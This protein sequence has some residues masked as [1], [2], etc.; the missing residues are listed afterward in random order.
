M[1]NQIFK[2]DILLTQIE[3]INENLIFFSDRDSGIILT[4]SMTVLQC[5]TRLCSFFVKSD[6]NR[7]RNDLMDLCVKIESFSWAYLVSFVPKIRHNARNALTQVVK[8]YRLSST[9][10]LVEL[11]DK[12]MKLSWK[13]KTKYVVLSSVA[14][15]GNSD[16]ILSACPDL[17]KSLMKNVQDPTIENLCSDLYEIMMTRF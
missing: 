2:V 17:T 1:N 5:V 12:A 14:K 13:Q 9:E 4:H 16:L 3:N 7:G 10:K 11:I 6:A 8:M 15:E